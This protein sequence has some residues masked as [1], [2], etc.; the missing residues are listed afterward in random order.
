[1]RTI[2]VLVLAIALAGCGTTRTLVKGVANPVTTEDMYRVEQ[3]AVLVVAGLNAYRDVCERG[4]ISAKCRDT[5]VQLQSF[6]RPAAAALRSLRIY[7]KNND[8]LN[9][10]N[11]Y[12]TLVQL[13]A[14]V[15]AVAQANGV[16]TQ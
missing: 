9:A 2:A 13:L 11:S 4:L 14:D 1:M 7:F 15:R 10:I 8:R 3:T 5:V 6:T 16:P 12:N